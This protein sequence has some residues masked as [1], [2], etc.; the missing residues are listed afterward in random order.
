M[1][2]LGQIEANAPIPPATVNR[3]RVVAERSG[4]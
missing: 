4:R 3:L 1:G 2:Y